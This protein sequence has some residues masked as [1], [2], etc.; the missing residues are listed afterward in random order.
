[1]TQNISNEELIAETSVVFVSDTG[2]ISN[3]TLGVGKP[4][5]KD[6]S[7]CCVYYMVGYKSPFHAY[8]DDTFQA[9]C[10]AIRMLHV[11]IKSLVEHA[12][13]KIYHD[14]VDFEEENYEDNYGFSFEA[15]FQQSAN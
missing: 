8:G 4:F 3:V 13:Y 1:M 7:A 2:K 5:Y 10:G 12:G 14:D 15:M 9:L 11:H 6:E